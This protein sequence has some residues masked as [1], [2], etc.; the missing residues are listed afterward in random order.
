MIHTQGAVAYTQ[1]VVGGSGKDVKATY[2]KAVLITVA[3]VLAVVVVATVTAGSVRFANRPRDYIAD[4][5][6]VEGLTSHLN[7]LQDIANKNNGNRA[8]NTTGYVESMRY[9]VETLQNYTDLIVSTQEIPY[10]GFELL[11]TPFLNQISPKTVQYIRG[12]DFEVL[13][14]SGSG[15]VTSPIFIVPEYGCTDADY[16]DFIPGYI[17]L[18]KT[19][20][21][22]TNKI[23]ALTA[24]ANQASALIVWTADGSTTLSSGYTR[25]ATIPTLSLSYT[26]GLMLS[27]QGDT[28]LSLQVSSQ[29][30]ELSSFNVIAETPD[31][32]SSAVVVVGAHLDSGEDASGIND[33]GS[34]VAAVLEMAL[35]VDDARYENKIVFG[36][37]GAEEYGLW[38]SRYYVQHREEYQYTIL[39]YLNLDMIGSPNYIHMILKASTAP[40]TPALQQSCAVIQDSLEEHFNDSGVPF[41]Y[42]AY[43]N[44]SDYGPFVDE[45]IAANSLQA[46]AGE[47]KTTEQRHVFGGIA[48]APCDPC[49]HLA[50][51]TMDNV[52]IDALYIE[53]K[54][55]AQVVHDLARESHLQKYL[56]SQ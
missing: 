9:V 36:F 21:N 53:A 37:W 42:S 51:D 43:A 19:K 44:N 4:H 17:A 34:G 22:C 8:A 28:T 25:G 27:E 14:Y 15:T 24:Q 30:V 35:N 10:W 50:C 48:H 38:G 23:K 12:D 2:K 55:C 45:G 52:D 46:G 56:Y 5:I 1:E 33:N 11:G 7:A 47:V 32:N 40:G 20:G 39:A 3:I 18:V 31:G 13:T 26:A 54:I 16:A 49:Y 29:I 6:T 41:G